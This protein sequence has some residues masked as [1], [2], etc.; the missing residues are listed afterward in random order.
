LVE[1]FEYRPAVG[2]PELLAASL[3]MA[4]L[5]ALALGA[6][7]H[8]SPGGPTLCPFRAVTG[9]PCP[10]CGLT[11]SLLALG[12]GDVVAVF[13]FSPLGLFVPFAAAVLLAHVGR[14][15]VLGR[16]VGWP[17]PLLAAGTG[18]TLI[19]WVFQMAKGAT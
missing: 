8:A 14:A 7:T 16:P 3:C 17:R 19:S 15:A 12:R 13:H 1:R 5:G 10:F 18:L 9:Y 2:A 6:A 11:R 4:S